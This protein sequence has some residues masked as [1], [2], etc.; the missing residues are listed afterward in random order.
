MTIVRGYTTRPNIAYTVHPVQG[1]RVQ[2]EQEGARV[3]AEE[4]GQ[5]GPDRLPSRVIVYY[6]YVSRADDIAKRIGCPVYHSKSGDDK[7]RHEVVRH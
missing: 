6:Q 7:A 3:V 4:V 1:Y 2:L 5:V